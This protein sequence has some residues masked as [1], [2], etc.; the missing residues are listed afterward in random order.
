MPGA[1]SYFW[2]TQGRLPLGTPL[3]DADGR[4]LS[5][6]GLRHKDHPELLFVLPRNAV[7]RTMKQYRQAVE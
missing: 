5:F 6:V 3:T 1:L 4:V 2:V 7:E